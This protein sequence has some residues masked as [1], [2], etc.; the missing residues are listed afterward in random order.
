M[1]NR[2]KSSVH[3]PGM[4]MT[5]GFLSF[6]LLFTG[7]FEGHI[8]LM[9]YIYVSPTVNLLTSLICKKYIFENACLLLQR[10]ITILKQDTNRS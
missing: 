7:V 1:S 8:R 4:H 6:F 5:K 3:A 9:T 2:A 10:I